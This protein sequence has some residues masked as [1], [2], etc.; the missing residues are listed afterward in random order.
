[1]APE[2]GARCR[3]KLGREGVL[4]SQFQHVVTSAYSGR[5]LLT[6]QLGAIAICGHCLVPTSAPLWLRPIGF[7]SH[8]SRIFLH[9]FL[10]L[11]SH[12]YL[13]HI[14][15]LTGSYGSAYHRRCRRPHLWGAGWL[16]DP[17]RNLANGVRVMTRPTMMTAKHGVGGFFH[18]A[19]YREDFV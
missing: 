9:L 5:R 11:N 7:P 8:L 4:L 17:H 15:V 13:A 18:P 3:I 2:W 12:T 16:P 14:P 1:M 10:Q 6:V 19:A